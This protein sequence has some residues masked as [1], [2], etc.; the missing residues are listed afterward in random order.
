MPSNALKASIP[1]ADVSRLVRARVAAMEAYA[2]RSRPCSVLMNANELPFPMP[3]ELHGMVMEALRSVELHRY[4]DLYASDLRE[5]LA[6]L[7]GV[8]AQCVLVGNG[9][10]EFIIMVISAFAEPP[11]KV[12]TLAPTFS[13]YRSAAEILGHEAIEVPLTSDWQLD[14]EPMLDAVRSQRPAV[15]FLSSPNNPSG[16]LFD[17]E[18][19]RQIVAESPGIVVVDEAYGDYAG[20]SYLPWLNEYA[21]VIVLRTL[22]KVG[23]A[24]ARLGVVVANPGIIHELW[25]VKPPYNINSMTQAVVRVVLDNY[26]VVA[27]FVARVIEERQRLV[28]WLGEQPHI[29]TYPSD[30]NFILFRVAGDGAAVHEALMDRSILVRYFGDRGVLR[31]CLRVTVGQPHENAAFREALGEIVRSGVG[32]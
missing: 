1:S 22:S 5:S 28:N 15:T 21:N 13:V 30:A 4:P 14:A 23:L 11:A 25:K 16:N 2:P 19:M 12:L 18:V 20:R 26:D 8:E 9:S 32:Q 31:N 10:D 17:D 3:D 29:V 24:G 7:L 27:P 6:R